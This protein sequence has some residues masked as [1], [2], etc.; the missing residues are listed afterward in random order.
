MTSVL[1][2]SKFWL[3]DGT[4]DELSP[5]KLYQI[6]TL[7]VHIPVLLLLV[8]MPS[9]QTKRTYSRFLDPLETFAPVSKPDK[10][11]LDFEIAPVNAF[12]KHHPASMLS[13]CYFHLSRKFIRKNGELGLKKL[14]SGKHEVALA[15]KNILALAFEN[16]RKYT[17]LSRRIEW[18]GGSPPFR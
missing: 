13:C 11:L 17:N 14:V 6:D 16:M 2:E 8:C 5:K 4:C 1:K 12:Q 7:H 15:L 9:F 10:V 3:A 18:C